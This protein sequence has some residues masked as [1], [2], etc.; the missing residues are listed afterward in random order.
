[1]PLSVRH[2]KAARRDLQAI[3]NYI[4][5]DNPPA[6]DGQLRRIAET[7]H[8]LANTPYMGRQRDE[9]AVGLR[10]IPVGR[11]LV[12]FDFNDTTLRIVRVIYSARDITPALF[13]P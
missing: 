13:E 4:S 11:Y 12:F 10:S 3:W 2:T 9:L 7:I 5:T 6:A 1:M 8:L